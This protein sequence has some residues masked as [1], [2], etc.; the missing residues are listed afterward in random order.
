MFVNNCW[1]AAGWSRDFAPEQ[2]APVTMLNEPIVIFR[3]G[4]GA[5]VALQDRC[6]HRF[7]P[8]GVRVQNWISSGPSQMMPSTS[9]TR[10]DIW[11]TYDFVVP[12]IFLLGAD[13][14]PE[15]TA[16]MFPDC[17]PREVEPLHRQFTCQAVTPLTNDRACY[18]FAYGP[19]TKE[20]ELMDAFYDLGLKAF[21]EDRTMIEAQQRSINLAPESK[22]VTIAID[23]GVAQF[24]RMM[25]DLI[26]AE[27]GHPV[28][29]APA[30]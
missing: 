12:G 11:Q 25:D 7:A 17:E 8:R 2:L 5:P 6:C 14:Y 10:T 23:S 24:H 21:N 16:R 9:K 20:A 26:R 18:I 13:F 22:M 27:S 19:W 4:E 3:T 15:G 30:S 28:A 1:Y 29:D